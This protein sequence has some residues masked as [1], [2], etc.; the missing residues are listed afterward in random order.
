[1]LLLLLLQGRKDSPS[2]PNIIRIVVEL[3][4]LQ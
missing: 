2:G 4:S 3:T 1:M